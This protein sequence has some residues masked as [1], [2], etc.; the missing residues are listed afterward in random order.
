MNDSIFIFSSVGSN[1]DNS[2]RSKVFDSWEIQKFDS[3]CSIYANESFPY[4]NYFNLVISNQNYKFPNFFYFNSI[5][6]IID[7]YKYIAILDDDLLFN[8]PN[9][10]NQVMLYMNQFNIHL[11]SLSNNNVGKKTY[12]KVM[13]TTTDKCI[14]ITNFCEMGCM[15][16]NNQ[17][18]K[19]IKDEY[20]KS[21]QDLK[22]WGFDWW[23]CSLANKYNYTIGIIKHLSFYNPQQ[24][25]RD[26]AKDSWKKYEDTI[27]LI[28]SE[29]LYK[30]PC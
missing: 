24:P 16:F 17:L 10:V 13:H 18:L 22:D 6:N 4:E 5:H 23:I 8:E 19:L 15:I 1:I 26:V 21:Y 7:R 25:V 3:G 28:K 27:Q 20:Y 11:C 9:S 12:Y 2:Y 30:I 29:T 14:E